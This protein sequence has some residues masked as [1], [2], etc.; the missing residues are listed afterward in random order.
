MKLVENKAL[1]NFIPE[2]PFSKNMLGLFLDEQS[3]DV[4]FELSSDDNSL[5]VQYHA[6]CLILKACAPALARLC[7][8]SD[9]SSPIVIPDVEPRVFLQLLLYIYGGDISPDWKNDAKKFIDAADKFGL[10]NLKLT[11]EAWYV[12]YYNF[13]VVN[14]ADELLYA[15]SMNC[16]L[17]REAAIN[18]ISK[19]VKEVMKSE[20]F[21][22][23]LMAKPASKDIMLAVASSGQGSDAGVIE[24]DSVATVNNLRVALY[25]K[26]LE[27]HGSRESLTSRL[28][29]KK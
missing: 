5:K 21:E 29:L 3:A 15:D 20:S 14:V 13:T 9:K 1:L 16:P 7:E 25:E 26:G 2:N 24:D 17:L 11:A 22:N 10:V 6:H 19:N 8:G 4:R 27:I 18:F 23:V 12:A 28:E